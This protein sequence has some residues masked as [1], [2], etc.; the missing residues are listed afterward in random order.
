[1]VT[2]CLMLQCYELWVIPFGK[3]RN[4]EQ[5]EEGEPESVVSAELI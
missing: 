1:M 3:I 4:V 5:K 2:L